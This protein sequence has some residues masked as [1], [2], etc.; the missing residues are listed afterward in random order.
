M[1]RRIHSLDTLR[2]L[3]ALVVLANHLQH[4]FLPSLFGTL[5]PESPGRLIMAPIAF[6]LNGSCA[7]AL[8]FVLSGFVLSERFISSSNIAS[9]PDAVI[10]RWPRLAGPVLTVNLLS[11]LLM[12][13]GLYANT[14]VADHNG[15]WWLKGLFNWTPTGFHDPFAAAREGAVTTFLSGAC[16]Y[17]GPLWTMHFELLGSMVVYVLSA[18]L[19]L[20]GKLMGRRLLLFL[21]GLFYL[22]ECLRFPFMACFILGVI[23][24]YVHTRFPRIVW[25]NSLLLITGLILSILVGGMTLQENDLPDCMMKG[26]GIVSPPASTAFHYFLYSCVAVYFLGVSL[27]CPAFSSFLS[28]PLLSPLGRLSFPI[29]LVHTP[30]I[31]FAGCRSYLWFADSSPSLATLVGI[32]VSVSLTLVLAVPLAAFDDLWISLVRYLGIRRWLPGKTAA[33]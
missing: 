29:Y 19:V 12:G 27:W 2:G 26:L 16:S 28:T 33:A 31:C 25:K 4:S 10:R 13:W 24:A 11:G 1:S 23:L 5:A 32:V 22:R 30:V 17:N 3:A 8:F 21:L 14:S 18:F 15:A 9:L 6:L 7:V 20:G